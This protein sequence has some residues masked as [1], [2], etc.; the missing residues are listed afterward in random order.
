MDDQWIKK[1]E[2]DA[3]TESKCTDWTGYYWLSD[4]KHPTVVNGKFYLPKLDP[5]QLLIEA[6]LYS[7]STGVT[8]HWT[9]QGRA[10]LTQYDS[11]LL[12]K[13]SEV[14]PKEYLS[15]RIPNKQK[16]CFDQIW[17]PESDPLGEGLEVLTHKA[18]IFKGFK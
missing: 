16:I 3:L 18:T 6:L 11:K 9:H 13:T 14:E 15:H 5:S 2:I 10:I 4:Q 7:P 8:I 17:I 12:P 1:I